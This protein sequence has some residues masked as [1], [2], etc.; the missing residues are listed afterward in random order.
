[1]RRGLNETLKGEAQSAGAPVR[2]LGTPVYLLW[3]NASVGQCLVG[4]GMSGTRGGENQ[5]GWAHK[6]NSW[7]RGPNA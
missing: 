5:T 7:G 3:A 4:R 1:M 6:S 2:P